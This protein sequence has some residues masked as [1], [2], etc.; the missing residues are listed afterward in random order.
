MNEK[1]VDALKRWTSKLSEF[2]AI[3]RQETSIAQKFLIKGKALFITGIRRSGKSYLGKMLSKDGIFI[4]C[5]DPIIKTSSPQEIFEGT[6]NV[7]EQ[8]K[9]KII[10]IDEVQE[11]NNF[12]ILVRNL[13]DYFN[14]PVI[15]TGSSSS[16][17]REDISSHLAGRYLSLELFPLSFSDYLRFLG[18]DTSLLSEEKA[19]AYLDSFM[20]FGSFPEVVLNRDRA[21]DLLLSYFSTVVIKDVKER[22]NVRE[23]QKLEMFARVLAENPATLLSLRKIG[24]NIGISPTTAENFSSYFNE[25]YFINQIQKYSPK[26]YE[27]IRSMKK[28]YLSDIGFHTIFY[29]G[30]GEK[31]ARAMENIVAIELFRRY[32]RNNIFYHSTPEGY[33][34]DFLVREKNRITKLIQVAYDIDDKNIKREL[35]A[36]RKAAEKFEGAEPIVITMNK[37]GTENVNGVGI[38]FVKLWKWLM[39]T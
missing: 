27:P 2:N 4:N 24:K 29:A 12:Q 14:L 3:E 1:L 39:R 11:I 32:G 13:L 15:V 16:I 36:L 18:I 10:F 28:S 25:V 37:E 6:I 23:G 8:K 35:R 19:F 30:R 5:E 20:E 34:V 38:R 22:Y 26:T 21:S 33:E 17:L 7:C 9:P 31:R